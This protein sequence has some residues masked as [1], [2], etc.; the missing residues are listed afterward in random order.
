MSPGSGA[1]LSCAELVELVTDYL[2]DAL[3]PADRAAFERHL[4]ECEGCTRY[5][6]QVEQT[7]RLLGSAAADRLP[8]E[9]RERLLA[10]FRTWEGVAGTD[11]SDRGP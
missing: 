4:E 8:E 1:G 10:A 6:A 3:V 7:I 5:L 11:S 2:E 9:A